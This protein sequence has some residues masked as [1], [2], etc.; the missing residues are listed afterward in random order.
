[1][2]A[3]QCSLCGGE[4]LDRARIS[5]ATQRSI[6]PRSLTTCQ[7]RTCCRDA[8]R[9][10]AR[11]VRAV[12]GTFFD[13][14]TFHVLASGTTGP[15]AHKDRRICATRYPLLS[16]QHFRGTAPGGVCFLAGCGKTRFMHKT[17]LESSIWRRCHNSLRMLKKAVQQGRSERRGEAYA[18]VR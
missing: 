6:L 10:D 9:H 1:M 8:L 5:S 13:S 3:R 16:S 7:F 15:P 4:R 14:A 18:S 17:P 11:C 2:Q 12:A